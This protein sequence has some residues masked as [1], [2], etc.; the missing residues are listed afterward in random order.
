[1]P[2]MRYGVL[3]LM[4]LLCSVLL[5]ACSDPVRVARREV[6][7]V[8]R[9]TMRTEVGLKRTTRSA[10]ATI[11]KDEGVALGRALRAAGCPSPAA[12]Q[13]AEGSPAPCK[14]IAAEGALRL[15]KRLGDVTAAARKVDKGV[16]LVYATL[17]IVLDLVEDIDA[18]LRGNGWQAKLAT[19]VTDVAKA[20][21][22]LVLAYAAYQT[23]F[24]G[25]Q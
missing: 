11:A 21:G 4:F 24:G 3:A 15:Q 8:S 9:A 18:G 16:G 1:M 23:T 10:L 6:D 22:D 12:T 2:T 20:W 25:V 19:V 5:Y 7:R 14:Q 13:P 17:L